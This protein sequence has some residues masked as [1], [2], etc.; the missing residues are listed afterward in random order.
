MGVEKKNA[1]SAPAQ[2]GVR[3]K[4][5]GGGGGGGGERTVNINML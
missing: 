3:E 5:I 4:R 2:D 1:S